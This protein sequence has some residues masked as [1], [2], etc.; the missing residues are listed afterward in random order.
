MPGWVR[1]RGEGKGEGGSEEGWKGK[2]EMTAIGREGRTQSRAEVSLE[3]D[4][5][6][7]RALTGIW[8]EGQWK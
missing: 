6:G 3:V 8:C 7:W 4:G 1:G 2:P 5:S